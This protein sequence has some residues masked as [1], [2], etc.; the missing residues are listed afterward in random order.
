MHKRE[1]WKSSFRTVKWNVSLR[2]TRWKKQL[3]QWK[4]HCFFHW[5]FICFSWKIEGKSYKSVTIVV[6][7]KSRPKLCTKRDKRFCTKNRPKVS[8]EPPFW[9][10]MHFH[11]DIGI[12]L[13]C[14]DRCGMFE[15]RITHK[16]NNDQMLKNPCKIVEKSK[17]PR[18]WL[19]PL[20]YV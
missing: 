13:R 11:L 7:H 8:S 9:A 17:E 4:M 2:S 10:N 14:Q 5:F 12:S 3:P 15:E 16:W 19:G 1:K 18:L 20:L 6:V